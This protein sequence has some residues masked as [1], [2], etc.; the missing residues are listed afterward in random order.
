VVFAIPAGGAPITFTL[1]PGT[2]APTTKTMIVSW[3]P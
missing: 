2:Y 1:P 3:E